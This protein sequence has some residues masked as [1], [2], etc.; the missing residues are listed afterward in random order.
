VGPRIALGLGEAQEW[1]VSL[2]R[3]R[4]FLRQNNA[5][6]GRVWAQSLCFR[7]NPSDRAAGMLDCSLRGG[8]AF[9]VTRG[10]RLSE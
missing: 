1:G 5:K 8:A 6:T 4:A 10:S 7:E 9:R 2:A 3:R